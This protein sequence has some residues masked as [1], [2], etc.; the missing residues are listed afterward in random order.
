[1]NIPRRMTRAQIGAHIRAHGF[2]ISDS[3]MDKLCAPA[4]DAGPPV[5]GWWG[6]RPLYDPD[7]ALAWA[8]ARI[9]PPDLAD[10]LKSSATKL[11]PGVLERRATKPEPEDLRKGMATKPDPGDE[12]VGRATR[13]CSEHS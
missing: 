6:R 7:V 3:T 11:D 5:A 4:T 10:T 12:R 13:A 8:E 9:C 2:P 1:M